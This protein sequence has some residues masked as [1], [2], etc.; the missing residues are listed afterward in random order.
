MAEDFRN[1]RYW[2]RE[3]ME[4]A[5]RPGDRVIDATMGNGH[6]TKWL[7][8]LVGETGKVYAFDVQKEALDNTRARLTQAGLE[9]RAELLLCG[10]QHM[11]ERV[12]EQVDAVLFNLGWLPGVE[13]AV[14]TRVETT[15]AAVNAALTLMKPEALMTVCI[16]PGHE[17]GARE[18]DALL[19]WASKLDPTRYDV[20]LRQYLNQPN[21]PPLMLAVRKR[22]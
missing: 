3:M 20:M 12:P 15:L 14:T 9:N 18:R 4:R 8:E 10:H 6:D 13:H 11:A 19:A 7:C 16:Y 21:C 5:I 22:P 2:A 1:A 17:E